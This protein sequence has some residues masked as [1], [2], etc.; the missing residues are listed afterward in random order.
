MNEKFEIYE[1]Q[2]GEVIIVEEGKEPEKRRLIEIE[3][4]H[5]FFEYTY[6]ARPDSTENGVYIRDVRYKLGWF[7]GKRNKAKLDL[8][9][10]IPNSGRIYDEGFSAATGIPHIV[11]SYKNPY[12]GRA[13]IRPQNI[14]DE[15]S[16]TKMNIEEPL[17]KGK[18]IGVTEDSIVRALNSINNN[19]DFRS[20]GVVEIHGFVGTPPLVDVC[21]EGIDMKDPNAFIAREKTVEEIAKLSGY[22]SLTYATKEELV[23]AIGLPANYLCMKC[24]GGHGPKFKDFIISP[25]DPNF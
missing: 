22:D 10:G 24:I 3:P 23:E 9:D 13:F 17:V 19:S 5:C 12:S 18:R 25:E 8:V 16:K 1:L 20:Q 14:R 4:K 6:L 15:I 2:G 11:V 7:L 21:E